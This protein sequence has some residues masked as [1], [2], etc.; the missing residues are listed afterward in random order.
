MIDTFIKEKKKEM[1]ENLQ[2]LIQIPSVYE[3]SK[4]PLMPFG[5]NANT[6]LEYMLNLGNQ[7]D[8]KTKNL[9]G[10]CGYIEFGEGEEMLGIIGH[11][12]V[13]PSGDNWTYPPF[14]RYYF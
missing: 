3:K 4:N 11:L 12:D 13:V 14:S 1:L 5:R 6:A 7:L 8:F 10:Y 2:K 9:D